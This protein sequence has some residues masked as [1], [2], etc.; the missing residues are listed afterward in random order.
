[1]GTSQSAQHLGLTAS[2]KTTPAAQAT[3]NYG[4]SP[5]TAV[6]VSI[7]DISATPGEYTVQECGFECRKGACPLP[8]VVWANRASIG[9]HVFPAAE[10]IAM[11]VTEADDALA[12]HHQVRHSEGV[13]S[14]APVFLVHSDI[15]LGKGQEHALALLSDSVLGGPDHFM[16][17]CGPLD[18]AGMPKIK[19]DRVAF[20]NVWLPISD[21]S[22]WREPL[23]LCDWRSRPADLSDWDGGPVRHEPSHQWCY[24]SDLQA[25]DAL[26]FKQWDSAFPE[27]GGYC[28]N[29]GEAPSGPP[30]EVLHSAFMLPESVEAR[31]RNEPRHSCEVRV[32]VCFSG[33]S[34]GVVSNIAREEYHRGDREY[35]IFL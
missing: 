29:V 8:A 1:M 12:F 18:G 26:I 7:V 27:G 31:C 16:S 2:L 6:A 13:L 24:Y 23:A 10:R 3:L 5:G 34:A 19:V 22:R 35:N 32:M 11:Q 25:G 21:S 33:A 9:R 15:V 30:R 4:T 17:S 14:E 20:V 28:S